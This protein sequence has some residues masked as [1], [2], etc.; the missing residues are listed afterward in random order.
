MDA[1]A[2][3]PD[4]GAL[5]IDPESRAALLAAAN[6]TIGRGLLDAVRY[7]PVHAINYDSFLGHESAEFRC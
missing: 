3:P 5:G 4:G 6:R 1:L 7:Y 2:E